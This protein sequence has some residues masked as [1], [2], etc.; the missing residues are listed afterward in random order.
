MA[1]IGEWLPLVKIDPDKKE[2]RQAGSKFSKFY[3]A[4]YNLTMDSTQT[5][6]EEKYF[7]FVRFLT[8]RQ[9]FGLEYVGD[10]GY[11]IKT[12]DIYTAAET[13]S[14]W[15][16][17]EQRRAAQIDKFQQIMSN[18]GSMLKALFQLLRELRIIDERL[19]YYDR[20]Y[21]GETAAEVALKSIWVDIVEGGSKNAGSVTGLASQVG[22]VTLPDLFYN[23][24]PKNIDN[25]EKEAEKLKE[26]GFNRKV[27]EVLARKLK[28]YMIWKEKTYHELKVGQQFKL[29]YLRQHYNVIK[30]YLN[31][32]RPYLKNIKRL[33]MKAG[34][35]DIDIISAFDTSK[36]ELEVL[37]IRTK[38][39]KDSERRKEVTK[40]K[41]YFPC[42]R[43]MWTFVGI[44]EL[45]YQQEYQRGALHRGRATI[46]IEGWAVK[47][48]DID[49]Y[50]K[51]MEKEDIDLLSAVDESILAL[52]DDL[53]K[54]LE[55]AGQVAKKE[56]EKPEKKESLFAPFK[57]LGEGFK[58]I[59]TGMKKM[60]KNNDPNAGEREGALKAVQAEAYILYQ[61]FKK[62]KGMLAE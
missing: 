53:D 26:G 38:Y 5:S 31:W 27:R 44:P 2:E 36:I 29:K 40:Y 62:T 56:E 43:I 37:A 51:E 14:Y 11:L 4:E 41:E 23:I 58:E 47:Q 54:Y 3:K 57:A 25:V 18:V 49:D 22:F 1:E 13:S 32:L 35:K 20:S 15:G 42:L 16:S 8:N 17:I 60:F 21:K 39:E 50:Q 48:S 28:Q 33:Q 52:K 19:D 12:K 34:G 6:V 24:H 9:P 7:W 46:R 59:T 30:M 45:A 55:K 10:Q 61:V